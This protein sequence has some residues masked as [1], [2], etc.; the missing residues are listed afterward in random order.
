MLVVSRDG[1]LRLSPAGETRPFVEGPAI[2]DP[3]GIAVDAE[4]RVLVANGGSLQNVSVFSPEG[5][6]LRS[7]GNGRPRIGR[8]DPDAVLEPWAL[9]IDERGRLWVTEHIGRPKRISVW[10][11]ASGKLL[12]EMFGAPRF[13]NFAGIDPANLNEVISADG[14]L[15]KVD[16]EKGTKRFHSTLWAKTAD[17]MPT[18]FANFRLVRADNA[19]QYIRAYRTSPS[20]ADLYLRRGDRAIPFLQIFRKQGRAWQDANGDGRYQ[21]SEFTDVGYL[22]GNADG[23]TC[24]R[25]AY[26]HNR[27]DASART[28]TLDAMLRLEPRHWGTAFVE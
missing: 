28:N 1:V 17:D 25:R 3:R 23:S 6:H 22:F 4:G 14:T 18:S 12:K 21:D 19:E 5:E 16:L 24:N 11:P 26:W 9:A 27:S 13:A 8:H 10:D 7:I 20:G 15:W 2:D